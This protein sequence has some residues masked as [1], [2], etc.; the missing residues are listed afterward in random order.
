MAN[1]C[2]S[3]AYTILIINFIQGMDMHK[4]KCFLVLFLM[5]VLA[6]AIDPSELIKVTDQTNPACVEYY[7]LQGDMYCSTR[8]LSSP[9][10]V[11]LADEKQKIIFDNR[12]WQAVWSQKT[13]AITTI[14]YVPAGDD[15]NN[16]KE[17]IT[18][19]FIPGIQ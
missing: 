10:K 13:P 5:P 16:W 4:I 15:I 6:V 3:F 17:L 9:V 1:N 7:N 19:Q 18:S 11:N 12:P 14:E 2:N 8:A